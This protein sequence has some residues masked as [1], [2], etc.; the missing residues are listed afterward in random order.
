MGTDFDDLTEKA[1]TDYFERPYDSNSNRDEASWESLRI[2]RRIL[3]H[4]LRTVGFFNWKYEWWH[5]DIGDC[6]WSQELGL[7]WIYDSM[8]PHLDSLL[9]RN[10]A[11]P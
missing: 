4:S 9:V 2:H 10:A 1:A 3:F 8:T 7:P 6:V 11:E 5:F